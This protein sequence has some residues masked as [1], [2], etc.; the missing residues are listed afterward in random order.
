ML[1]HVEAIRGRW[2]I[3]KERQRAPHEKKKRDWKTDCD[4]GF[5]H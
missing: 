2:R 4:R 5:A 1:V 3:E